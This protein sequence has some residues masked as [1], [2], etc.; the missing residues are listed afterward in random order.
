MIMMIVTFHRNSLNMFFKTCFGTLFV[1]LTT[2]KAAPKPTPTG[3]VTPTGLVTPSNSPP[4]N[5]AKLMKLFF[6]GVKYNWQGWLCDHQ[7]STWKQQHGWR[8]YNWAS[9]SQ[10]EEYVNS[11]AGPLSYANLG[12]FRPNQV[13]SDLAVHK[14]IPKPCLF[15]IPTKICKVQNGADAKP[16]GTTHT[17][18]QGSTCSPGV[19]T[20]AMLQYQ[21]FTREYPR[22]PSYVN[23]CIV[24]IKLSSKGSPE[25]A[26]EFKMAARI[27]SYCL[28]CNVMFKLGD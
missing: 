19:Q 10:G 18:A 5:C 27:V 8:I 3:Q 26:I 25:G 14:T 20:L 1:L 2:V 12:I 24:L 13:I 22:S 7:I 23:K 4:G 16:F 28:P 17:Y 9:N 21:L 11:G 6:I 15:L